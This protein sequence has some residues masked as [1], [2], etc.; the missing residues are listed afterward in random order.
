M[1]YTSLSQEQRCQIFTLKK[2]VHSQP[3]IA[4]PLEFIVQPL[5][6]S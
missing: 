5:V 6:G 3:D 4:K 1:A 2:I